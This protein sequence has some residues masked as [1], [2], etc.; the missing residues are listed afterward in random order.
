MVGFGRDEDKKGDRSKQGSNCEKHGM[1]CYGV[2]SFS[3]QQK[4]ALEGF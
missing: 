3:W 4:A 1:P 2:W